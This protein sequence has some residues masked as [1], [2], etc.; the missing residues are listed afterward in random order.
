MSVPFSA[1]KGQRKDGYLPIE[2]LL[3]D[4]K[5]QK[6]GLT[7]NMIRRIVEDDTKERY[8]LA[9]IQEELDGTI[10]EEG[11]TVS[12]IP[13]TPLSSNSS[14]SSSTINSSHLSS[15]ISTLPRLYIRANQGHSISVVES[16]ELCEEVTLFN[17]SKW[18]NEE[19]ILPSVNM[20]NLKPETHQQQQQQIFKIVS[21]E[22]GEDGL[23]FANSSSSSGSSKRQNAKNEIVAYHGTTR[24]NWSK[25]KE[26]GGISKMNRRHVHM[27][28][29]LNPQNI[30]L[31]DPRSI[32]ITSGFRASSEVALVLDIM[33]LLHA[34]IPV[35]VSANNVV[36][37]SGT[38]RGII[39]YEYVIRVHDCESG[40]IL[41]S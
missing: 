3:Q 4:T 14:S 37:S 41:P 24:L 27:A 9:W 29:K 13:T 28:L 6:Y 12:L 20:L 38:D 36:L 33:G 21:Q 32:K 23:N 7:E 40:E 39:P 2:V 26:S 31:E 34:N 11:V 16:H 18:W 35:F 30:A 25:I 19:L 1:L 15:S 8:R 22:E 5:C 17:L 10:M